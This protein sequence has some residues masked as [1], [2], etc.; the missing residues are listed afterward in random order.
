MRIAWLELV[1]SAMCGFGLAACG[2]HRSAEAIP[3][4]APLPA[5]TAAPASSGGEQAAAEPPLDAA[6]L[7][8]SWME[9]WALAGH[10]DTQRYTFRPDGRFGWCAAPDTNAV[11]AR[12]WGRYSL[13]GEDLVLSVQGEDASADCDGKGPCRS[14]H[15]PALEQRLPL[16]ACPPNDEARALDAHYRCISVGGQA[17]WLRDGQGKSDV[18]AAALAK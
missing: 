6:S 15:Q 13:E 7:H 11:P 16:G 5:T 8:G 14:A 10:A 12:R 18:E 17:F 2:C 3:E 1:V 4:I 9:Y